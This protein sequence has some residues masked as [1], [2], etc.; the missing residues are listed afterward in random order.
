LPGPTGKEIERVSFKAKRHEKTGHGT[1]EERKR[2][3]KD[4]ADPN[5]RNDDVLQLFR[6]MIETELHESKEQLNHL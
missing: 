6:G 1:E 4:S 5:E 2:E 3:E